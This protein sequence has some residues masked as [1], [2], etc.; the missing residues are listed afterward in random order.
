MKFLKEIS[1]GDKL[2][3][4]KTYYNSGSSDYDTPDDVLDVVYKSIDTGE[5]HIE[6]FEH[7]KIEV[8]VVKEQFRTFKHYP[9]FL[10]KSECDSYWV[11]YKTRFSDIGKILGVS[12]EKA[13]KSNLIG[14]IDM[15]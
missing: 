2:M 11:P 5:I 10:K 12:A 15:D 7:P 9:N 13:K 4:L 3:L 8:F 1:D 6:T 14:Q